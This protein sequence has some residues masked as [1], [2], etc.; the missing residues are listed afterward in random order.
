LIA[1]NN[2]KQEK[3]WRFDAVSVPTLQHKERLLIATTSI[4]GIQQE[5]LYLPSAPH[6]LAWVFQCTF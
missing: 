5:H 4:Q 3:K 1:E 6:Y 2:K